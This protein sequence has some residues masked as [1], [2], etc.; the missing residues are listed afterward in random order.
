MNESTQTYFY[1]PNRLL[2][3]VMQKIGVASD[4]AL[5]ARLRVSSAIIRSLR[6]G[7]LPVGASLL[8]W[9]SEISDMTVVELRR[10]L[11]DRRA[12]FRLTAG[13]QSTEAGANVPENAKSNS[14]TAGVKI[15]STP[16]RRRM[17]TSA[18]CTIERTLDPVG[19]DRA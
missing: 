6:A 11:G 7:T 1:D 10:V 17:E 2:N 3:M 4:E 13:R 9:M 8:I 19:P 18:C 15:I 5:T 12:K 16:V 14:Y